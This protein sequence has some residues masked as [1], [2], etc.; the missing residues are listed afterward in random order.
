[1]MG[2]WPLGRKERVSV[3]EVSQQDEA[4]GDPYERLCWLHN[5]VCLE[6]REEEPGEAPPFH[7]LSWPARKVG[8]ALARVLRGLA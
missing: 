4:H 5:P 8:G 7:F 6:R 2:G 3:G 1:M